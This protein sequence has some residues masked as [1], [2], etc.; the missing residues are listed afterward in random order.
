VSA[1]R[2]RHRRGT[3]YRKPPARQGTCRFGERAARGHDVVNQHDARAGAGQGE[4]LS[5]VPRCRCEATGSRAEALGR[6]ELGGVR[7]TGDT[8]QRRDDGHRTAPCAE[9]ASGGACDPAHVLAAAPTGGA[10]PGR[11]GHQDHRTVGVGEVTQELLDGDGQSIAED[12][13]QLAATPVLVGHHCGADGARVVGTGHERWQTR[14]ARIWPVAPRS[15]EEVP[16][17]A[18]Q[19]PERARAADARA[20]QE[21]VEEQTDHGSDRRRS[22]KPPKGLRADL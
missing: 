22:R 13:C 18:A 15:A 3:V 4:G 5:C 16:T 17:P 9:P 2:G 20:G 6:R 1:L 14:R 12:P 11:H 8:P 10:A 7:R 21:Q 19:G